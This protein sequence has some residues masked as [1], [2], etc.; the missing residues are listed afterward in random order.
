MNTP[1]FVL[2]ATLL[3]WGW[4]TGFLIPGAI[5]GVIVESSRFVKI[6]WD[7][8]DDDFKRIWS[9]CALLFLAATV[10][11]FADSGGPEGM[12]NLVRGSSVSAQREAGLAT[13]RTAASLIRWVP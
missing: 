1:P 7:I 2:G 13:A 6:R 5:M 4:Q 9:F 3:F 10:Y 12:G 11:A 8:S